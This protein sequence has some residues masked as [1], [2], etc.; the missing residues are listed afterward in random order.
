MLTIKCPNCSTLLKVNQQA[1][2]IQVKCPK[3][4]TLLKVG[5]QKSP[6]PAPSPSTTAPAASAKPPGSAGKPAARKG[7]PKPAPARPG[8]P[9][10]QT[11]QGKPAA[12]AAPQDPFAGAPAPA[13]DPFGDL[14]PADSLGAPAPAGGLDGGG[15][16]DFGGLDVPAASTGASPAGNP[17]PAA[18]PFP[19]KPKPAAK[20]AGKQTGKKKADKPAKQKKEKSGKGS[21][22]KL[23][24][25]LGSALGGAAV[26]G[27]GA[28]VAI[29]MLSKQGDSETSTA[30][31]AQVQTPEGFKAHQV[32]PVA[33]AM[34]EGESEKNP[35]TKVKS[36][37]IKSTATGATYFVGVNKYEFLNP[38]QAQVE[39]RAGRILMSNIYASAKVERGGK[40]GFA[41]GS[42][43]GLLYPPM[44]VE[45]YFFDNHVIVAGC[46][47]PVK[48]EPEVK[49]VPGRPLEPQPP[50]EPTE[51]EKKLA[52]LFEAEKKKFFDSI[53]L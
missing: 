43:R 14:P 31:A 42:S 16:F 7:A 30:S 38:S 40:S 10:G 6:A 17:M 45:F 21:N 18:H 49:R 2:A 12:P 51:E 3:C 32:G 41:G 26:L 20:P 8:A 46:G 29:L 4:A 50:K 47:M 37:V 35:S 36:E 13:G 11:P 28:T 15:G 44:D 5:P 22:K 19:A 9:R 27:I 1:V 39:L 48:E 25:I 23:F 33:F 52:E 34:P 53:V 24:I